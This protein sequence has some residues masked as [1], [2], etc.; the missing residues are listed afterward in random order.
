MG[1]FALGF[2]TRRFQFYFFQ[3][4]S[5]PKK[6]FKIANTIS[7]TTQRELRHE[8]ALFFSLLYTTEGPAQPRKLRTRVFGKYYYQL[9]LGRNTQKSTKENVERRNPRTP[10]PPRNNQWK[11]GFEL[12]LPHPFVVSYP[13]IFARGA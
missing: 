13:K 9:W 5:D 2:D 1:W 11:N 8:V 3:V 10:T 12:S 6:K 4:S 7:T